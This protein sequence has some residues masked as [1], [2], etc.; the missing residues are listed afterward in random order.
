[1]P[2]TSAPSSALLPALLLL[3]TTFASA[4][5]PTRSPAL[6]VLEKENRT[7]AIIDP[8]TLKI[9]ARVPAGDDPHEVAVSADGKTAYITNYGAFRTPLHTISVVDLVAQKALPAID[10]G[11]LLAP[12]GIQTVND[13]VYFTV[14]GSKAIARFDPALGKVAWILGVGQNRDHM[15]F[16]T[17][18]EQRIFT[19][20]VNSDTISIF[21]HDKGADVSGWRQNLIPVGKGPEG[22]AVSPGGKELWAANSHDGT[23]SVI[24]VAAK[25]VI[26]TFDLQTKFANRVQFTPD[27]RQVLISDLGTGD[28]VVV[29][30]N[31]RQAIKRIGLG[32]GAAGILIPPDG[33]R[34]FVAVSRDNYIAVLDLKT[35]AVTGRIDT[36]V[37]PDGMAWAVRH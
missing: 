32:H 17:T 11:A 9:I 26:Q 33:A 7:L 30:S 35:L 37:G 16:V 21:E 5:S 12:H 23:V 18:D 1:M 8:A 22:F 14:E 10:L 15:L 19:S 24:D 25:K 36:G 29:D 3:L 13:Q 28:L 2:R 27:G 20:D 31:T 34:A 4:Q 6:L